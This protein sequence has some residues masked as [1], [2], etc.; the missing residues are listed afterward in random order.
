MAQSVVLRDKKEGARFNLVARSPEVTGESF[1]LDP[2]LWE[3]RS[4]ISEEFSE[5]KINSSEYVI[6]ATR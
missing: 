5:S 4:R 3:L 1:Y 6:K 2:E